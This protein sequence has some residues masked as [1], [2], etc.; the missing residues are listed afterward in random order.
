MVCEELALN[1]SVRDIYNAAD[2]LDSLVLSC[3]NPSG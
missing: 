2:V 1:I 3:G